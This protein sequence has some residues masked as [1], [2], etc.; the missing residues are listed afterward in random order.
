LEDYLPVERDLA[1]RA[2]EENFATRITKDCN[3]EEV[4]DE[5]RKTV[6]HACIWW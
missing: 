4:V 2:V 1:A 6:S 5:S 3:G